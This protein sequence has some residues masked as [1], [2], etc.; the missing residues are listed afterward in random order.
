VHPRKTLLL[1]LLLSPLSLRAEPVDEGHSFICTEALASLIHYSPGDLRKGLF[2]LDIVYATA[3]LPAEVRDTYQ[4]AL[5][6]VMK[7]YRD[8]KRSLFP[9]IFLQNGEK[10]RWVQQQAK[11]AAEI[12]EPLPEASQTIQ[13]YKLARIGNVWKARIDGIDVA[14]R[15]LSEL[16]ANPFAEHSVLKNLFAVELAESFG[17]ADAVP[18]FAATHLKVRLGRSKAQKLYGIIN[19]LL[20][21]ETK[22][23]EYDVDPLKFLREHPDQQNVNNNL[24][25]QFLLANGD[26]HEENFFRTPEG[27][28]VVFDMGEALE[29]VIAP[30]SKRSRSLIG[31]IPPFVYTDEQILQLER[32]ASGKW[33]ARLL[34]YFTVDQK[35]ALRFRAEVLLKDA[36][37]RGFRPRRPSR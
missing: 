37:L 2:T 6:A 9:R 18:A 34:K 3:D 33:R 15:P 12:L 4:N 25:V 17:A 27:K 29:N 22:I 35:A 11:A 21:G 23:K 14:L 8:S 19:P 28:I 31:T 24:L 5:G 1:L 30:Y 13:A 32:I 16:D 7:E 36:E 26:V 10:S 20:Y